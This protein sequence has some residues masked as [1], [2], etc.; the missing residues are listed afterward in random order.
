MERSALLLPHQEILKLVV[1]YATPLSHGALQSKIEITLGSGHIKGPIGL[2]RA[3]SG[4]KTRNGGGF[5]FPYRKLEINKTVSFILCKIV[6]RSLNEPL[7]QLEL[8]FSRWL[9]VRRRSQRFSPMPAMPM[10][11]TVAITRCPYMPMRVCPSPVAWVPYMTFPTTRNPGHTSTWRL[12]DRPMARMPVATG[13]VSRNPL[14]SFNSRW[15]CYH[16]SVTYPNIRNIPW[17][18][19]DQ[20]PSSTD[21]GPYFTGGWQS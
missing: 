14:I 21:H 13:P 8:W 6:A 4:K 10:T 2:R 1:A 16:P 17:R 20:C 9:P 11:L 5:I 3:D 18:G 15:W 19:N 12:K 7:F